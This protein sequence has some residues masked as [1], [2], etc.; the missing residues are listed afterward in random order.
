[1]KE[2]TIMIFLAGNNNLS[3]DMITAIN[4]IKAGVS[5]INDDIAFLAQYDCQHPT[6]P[7]H[8]FDFLQSLSEELIH[9]DFIS[10]GHSVYEFVNWCVEK[11]PAKRYALI[12][13][14]HGDG[15]QGK[16]LLLDESPHRVLTLPELRETLDDIKTFLLGNRK[17]DILGFDG[18]V[19]NTLEGVYEMRDLADVW[20]GSQGSIP[21]AGW[22]YEKIVTDL[23]ILN[24]NQLKNTKE[25]AKVFVNSFVEHNKNYSFGGRSVDISACNLSEVDNI[26]QNVNELSKTLISSLNESQNNN[27]VKQTVERMLLSSH[28]KSQTFMNDQ[29]IDIRDFCEN[30]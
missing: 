21:N 14:G 3:D 29:T 17:I 22:T 7:I 23:A 4:D 5:S 30:L 9:D 12:L 1:M 13:S 26:A 6:V 2:W 18:C 28:W 15:F 11:Q 24:K 8:R 16:T 10:I 27:L 19:M 25:V 20:V